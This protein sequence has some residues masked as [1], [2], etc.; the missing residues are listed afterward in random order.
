MLRASLFDDPV[1]GG[2]KLLRLQ[3]LLQGGVN[4]SLRLSYYEELFRW[5]KDNFPLALNALSPEEVSFIA[6]LEGLAVA[7]VLERLVS[8]GLDSLPG[9]GAEILDDEIRQRISP[10]KC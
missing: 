10:L 2:R 1:F 3:V 4:P 8:A 7:Q 5:I 6:K 9:G